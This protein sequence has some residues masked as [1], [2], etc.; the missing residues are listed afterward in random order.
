MAEDVRS[1]PEQAEGTLDDHSTT[2]DIELEDGILPSDSSSFPWSTT[3]VI[4]TERI[5]N[6]QKWTTQSL[7]TVMDSCDQPRS[8]VTQSPGDYSRSSPR[9]SSRFF[10]KCASGP[11]EDG[12]APGIQ[13]PDW[14]DRPDRGPTWDG[15]VHYCCTD[16][17]W[18]RSLYQETDSFSD[19]YRGTHLSLSGA[20]IRSFDGAGFDQS[21]A[22]L[23]KK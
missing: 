9:V 18:G 11:H 23:T 15:F 3:V 20:Y 2:W 12:S 21:N 16:V 6:N 13:T 4:D 5:W 17:G 7:Q 22:K 10:S 19:G 14:E 8:L 1:Q